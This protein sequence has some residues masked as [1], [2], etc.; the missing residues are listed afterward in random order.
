MFKRDSYIKLVDTKGN[1]RFGYVADT[2][3]R[4]FILIIDLNEEGLSKINWDS[5]YA[6]NNDGYA[7]YPTI[8]NFDTL[9]TDT[10]KKMIPLLAGQLSTKGIADQMAIVPVTVR[11]HIRDLKIK[12][13]LDTREQ[14]VAYSQ[15]IVKTLNGNSGN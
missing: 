14:L 9:L 5:E 1:F 3:D 7:L 12:L 13:Q 8:R 11:A 10:E 15:G 4:G 6:Q 2:K